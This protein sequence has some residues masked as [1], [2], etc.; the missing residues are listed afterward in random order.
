MPATTFT[1]FDSSGQGWALGVT[2]SGSL[3]VTATNVNNTPVTVSS[4]SPQD[5]INLVKNFAHGIPV[6]AVQSNVCDAINSMI[7]CFYPWSWTIKSLTPITLV[8]GVQD[9]SPTDSDILRPTLLRIVRTDTTPNEARELALLSN[10]GVELTRKGGLESITAVGLLST[11]AIRLMYAASVGTGQTLQLQGFY[12]QKPT[13]ITDSTLST[14]FSF[15]DYYYNVFIE[16]L[17]WKMYQLADDPRAGTMQ[18]SKNG[19]MMRQ[20]TG[21]YGIFMDALLTMARTEDLKGGDEFQFPEQALG[22]G[23]SFWPGLYGL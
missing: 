4:Y 21:Q 10:L 1:I 9:Y 22:S 20:Y 23:R 3:Q 11:G 7:W 17:K 18:Y 14:P 16:G 2:T 19:T 13:R 15:P 5:A 8:D 12:Q 6:D